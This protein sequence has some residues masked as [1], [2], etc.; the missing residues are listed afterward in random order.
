MIPTPLTILT[1]RYGRVSDTNGI[2]EDWAVGRPTLM[3]AW[4]QNHIAIYAFASQFR[5]CPH[6]PPICADSAPNKFSAKNYAVA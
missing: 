1:L 6:I 3:N 2:T 4:T 5:R